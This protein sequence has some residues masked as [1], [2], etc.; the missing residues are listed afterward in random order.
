MEMM[1]TPRNFHLISEPNESQVP[2]SV[3]DT[4]KKDSINVSYHPHH[5]EKETA[6][7]K[8]QQQFKA[9]K[10]FIMESTSAHELLEDF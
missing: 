6:S 3:V 4:N 10:T 2:V 7:G 5:V 9:A 1:T 8:A